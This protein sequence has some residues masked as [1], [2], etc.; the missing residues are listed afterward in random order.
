MNLRSPLWPGSCIQG[1]SRRGLPGAEAAQAPPGHSVHPVR[2][3]LARRLS[4][5]TEPSGPAWRLG[6]GPWGRSR[7]PG[8]PTARWCDPYRYCSKSSHVWF[9]P[10]V[11]SYLQPAFHSV[12][13]GFRI[14]GKIDGPL[15]VT[16]SR[17]EINLIKA[18]H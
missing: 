9:T 17:V 8:T 18:V 12:C 14:A 10:F 7:A 6:T 11:G 1:K 2:S 3:T 15:C 13:L 16:V 5:L 4:E